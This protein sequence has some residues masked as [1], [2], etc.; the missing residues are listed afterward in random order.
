MMKPSSERNSNFSNIPHFSGIYV[1]NIALNGLVFIKV[2]T[3][4]GIDLGPGMN[5]ARSNFA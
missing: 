1:S 2:W 3:E 5:S 4:K